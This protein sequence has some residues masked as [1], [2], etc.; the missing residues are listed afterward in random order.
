MKKTNTV[1]EQ[2]MMSDVAWSRGRPSRSVFILTCI[3]LDAF[4]NWKYSHGILVRF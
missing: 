2:E 1:I 3:P 4:N